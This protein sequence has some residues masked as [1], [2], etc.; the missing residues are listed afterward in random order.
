[1]ASFFDNLADKVNNIGNKVVE[2]TTSSTENIR[3]SNAIKEEERQINEDYLAIGKKYRELF[4]NSPEPDFAQFIS[5]IVRREAVIEEN[6]KKI[7]K[8]KGKTTCE[9]CGT[10]IDAAAAFCT[11]CGTKNPIADE[12]AR[13][14]AEAQAQA[15]A[16]AAAKA[17]AKAEA[18]AHAAEAKA[19]AAAA[20]A[21][22]VSAQAQAAADTAAQ[23]QTDPSPAANETVFCKNCGNAITVGNAFCTNCGT[24][25][26]Q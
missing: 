6:R 14:K 16:E 18:Q 20:N 15:A 19:Q 13:E 12:I 9:N 25:V 23:M 8:N 21:A 17:Q 7:Q 5:D 11:K 3:L 1:M 22:A 24:R 2:K 10:E 26:D 4:G